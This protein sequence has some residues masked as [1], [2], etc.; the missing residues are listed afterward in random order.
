MA[1]ILQIMPPTIPVW[2]AFAMSDGSVQFDPIHAW[3][4]VKEKGIQR[5]VGGTM[6][7]YGGIDAAEDCDNFLGYAYD[8]LGHWTDEVKSYLERATQTNE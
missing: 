5:I 7:T 1:K 3:L 2:A 4:L 6:C 8:K